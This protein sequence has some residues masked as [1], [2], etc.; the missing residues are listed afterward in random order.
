MNLRLSKNEIR[1]FTSLSY[2]KRIFLLQIPQH[3]FHGHFTIFPFFLLFV[4]L[5]TH[6]IFVAYSLTSSPILKAK[7]MFDYSVVQ[8]A[9]D[10]P[11]STKNCY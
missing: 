5:H 10:Q 11:V 6:Y 4:F 2:L 1:P 3:I 9:L 8:C 7:E